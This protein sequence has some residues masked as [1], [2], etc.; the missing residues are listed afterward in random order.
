MEVTPTGIDGLFVLSPKVWG[1]HRGYFMK[2]TINHCW[3][4]QELQ[5]NFVQ[6]T[7]PDRYMVCCVGLHYQIQHTHMPN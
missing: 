7:K 2:H 5:I 4:M 6:T 1:D 3:L